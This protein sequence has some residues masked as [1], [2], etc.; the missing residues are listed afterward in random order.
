MTAPPRERQFWQDI[1]RWT[2]RYLAGRVRQPADRDDLAQEVLLKAFRHRASL[3]QPDQ[4]YGWL[5]RIADTTLADH[6][7]SRPPEMSGDID[8]LPDTASADCEPGREPIMAYLEELATDLPPAYQPFLS[9]QPRGAVARLA[10]THD[11]NPATVKT[12]RLRGRQWLR[13]RMEEVCTF[14]RTADGRVQ[15][16]R[17]IAP[18]KVACAC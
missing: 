11:M 13:R 12:R 1:D 10:T 8:L 14:E 18:A 16:C 2:R 9:E 7:R 3:R 5:R 15:S 17:V 6:W 4:L